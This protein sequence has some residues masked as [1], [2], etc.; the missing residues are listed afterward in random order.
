[1]VK[2]VKPNQVTSHN[3]NIKANESN[4][5]SDLS[6]IQSQYNA[7]NNWLSLHKKVTLD[8]DATCHA[9]ECYV[10]N[11]LFYHLKFISSPDM[12]MFNKDSRLIC[13]VASSRFGVRKEFQ[14]T[15]W[16]LHSKE[17]SKI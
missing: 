7:S 12:I 9:V 10:K 1:M 6:E 8:N 17:I 11:D 15:F 4:T 5:V 3:I 16:S 13:Q 14:S 2:I